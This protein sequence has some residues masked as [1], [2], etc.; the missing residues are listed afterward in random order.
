VLVFIV[1]WPGHRRTYDYSSVHT[2]LFISFHSQTLVTYVGYEKTPIGSEAQ[3]FFCVYKHDNCGYPNLTTIL[4]LLCL[5]TR[6][7]TSA[8]VYQFLVSVFYPES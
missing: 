6:E 2:A 8:R 5:V 3:K 7:I 4:C 1:Y